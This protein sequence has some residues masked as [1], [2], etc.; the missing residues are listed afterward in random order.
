MTWPAVYC[1]LKRTT[2]RPLPP[3]VL[4][5]PHSHPASWALASLAAPTRAAAAA[6]HKARTRWLTTRIMIV[7][8][9]FRSS[10]PHDALALTP[11]V[12]L[13]GAKQQSQHPT[14]GH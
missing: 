10:R 3:Q 12:L 9:Q 1:G 8:L 7:H 6:A 2:S 5:P 4:P 11:D 13:R 14:R